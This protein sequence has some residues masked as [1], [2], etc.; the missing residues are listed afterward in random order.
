[1]FQSEKQT[2][3]NLA[4]Q[5]MYEATK[6]LGKRSEVQLLLT[7][8]TDLV[9]A[10]RKVREYGVEVVVV[11]PP[12]RGRTKESFLP[13]ASKFMRVSKRHLRDNLLPDPVL[14]PTG[15]GEIYPLRAPDGWTPPPA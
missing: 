14:K 7:G 8:D 10:V 3:V 13:V 1:M 15:S 6:P 2:D 11:A 5:M 12:S 9:P 4:V